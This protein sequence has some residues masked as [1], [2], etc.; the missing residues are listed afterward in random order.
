MLAQVR[1]GVKGRSP[2]AG[3][4]FDGGLIAARHKLTDNSFRKLAQAPSL[5]FA[6]KSAVDNARED[7]LAAVEEP[8]GNRDDARRIGPDRVPPLP[9]FSL[10]RRHLQRRKC[11]TR[12]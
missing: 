8:E 3:T 2:E 7:V 12:R 4:D 9:Q 6:D 1:R 11:R 10:N 5:A